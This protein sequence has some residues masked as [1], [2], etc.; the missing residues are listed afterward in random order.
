MS[1]QR[2]DSDLAEFDVHTDEILVNMGPQHP[3]THGVLRLVLR[4]DGEVVLDV[5][6]AGGQKLRLGLPGIGMN[7]EFGKGVLHPV[8]LFLQGAVLGAAPGHQKHNDQRQQQ[9]HAQQ[10]EYERLHD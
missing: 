3:S 6:Q 2:V 1:V 5:V 9:D 8:E 4:T 10:Y 7:L